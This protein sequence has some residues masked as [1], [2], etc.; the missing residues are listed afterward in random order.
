MKHLLVAINAKYIHTNLAIRLLK[1]NT[2]Y[3]VDM[4]E[5]TLKDQTDVVVE[6][7]LKRDC[8][9]IGFSCYIWNISMMREIWKR[10]KESNANIVL[11]AGGPEVSYNPDTYLASG[12]L[13]YVIKNEGEET[14]HLLLSH[15]NGVCVVTEV[16][17]LYYK[18]ENKILY[19]FDKMVNLRQVQMAYDLCDDLSNRVIY[20]E[21]SR[22][23]P[24]HCTYCMASLDNK[25]RFFDLEEIKRQLL[26]LINAGARTIKFLDRT[27]NANKKMFLELIYFL[28]EHHVVGQS[29]QFEIT[30]DLLEFEVLEKIHQIIPPK[31][32]RFE[33]GI[34]ST[35]IETNLLVERIQNN[36]KLFQ[37][38]SYIQEQGKIDLHL[39]LI[40]GL[41]REDLASFQKSFLDVLSLKPKELQLGFLKVLHGTKL[42]SQQAEFGYVFSEEPPYEIIENDTL[43]KED[44]AYIHEVEEGLELFYN[45]GILPRTF[46]YLIDQM[47]VFHLFHDLMN[48][49]PN[50][51]LKARF[52]T[53][54]VYVKDF[55]ARKRM[56]LDY[57][58]YFQIKPEVWW[59]RV[60][61]EKRHTLIMNVSKLVPTLHQDLLFRYGVVVELENTFLL[62]IYKPQAKAIYEI[63]LEQKTVIE[64]L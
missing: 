54:Y 34:Q 7:L 25:V 63:N 31:L 61:K 32:F 45:S 48:D 11:I 22:G 59:D 3:E 4:V 19:T 10:L 62:A 35:N 12:L 50:K 60:S 23:C 15:L 30:G 20:F 41:P 40:A 55:E 37:V 33:I 16:P 21:T 58:S 57:F 24:F 18:K 56:F 36:E 43:S 64:I 39:D 2:S 53:L 27:F 5:Y 8:Q 47:D 52:Q 28:S 9:V 42:E 1:K 13:D 51:T 6:D 17:N 46:D 49:L 44:I 26:F 14:F 38:I 29:F